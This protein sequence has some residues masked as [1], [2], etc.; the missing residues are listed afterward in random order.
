M[1]DRFVLISGCSGGGKSTLLD[2]LASRRYQTIQ[3]PGRRI[4]AE[5]TA[6]GGDALPWIDMA[7]FLNRAIDVALADR[8]GTSS[9]SGWVFFDRGLVDA[10]SAL[11]AT[12]GEPALER[13]C[14]RHR[15]N[16]LVFMAPP[17]PEIYENDPD[18]RHSFDD[19]VAEHERLMRDYP[20]LGYDVVVLPKVS[21]DRRAEF[22][23]N[24]LRG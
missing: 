11:E 21:V 1:S 17:W 7:S 10:A 2:A 12:T 16:R 15:Y 14:L 24:T 20:L 23:L 19:A 4:V 22:V 13:L 18:R 8:R 5:Q 3:E 9:G 6:N